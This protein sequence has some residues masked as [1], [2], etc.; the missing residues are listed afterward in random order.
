MSR[1]K[2]RKKPKKGFR[3]KNKNTNPKKEDSNKKNHGCVIFLL[4]IFLPILFGLIG[5]NGYEEAFVFCF[6]SM[7][8]IPVYLMMLASGVGGSAGGGSGS[9]GDGG[10]DGGGGCGGCGGCGGGCGG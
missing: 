9:G 3:I 6:L 8:I 10:G 7:G 5:A 4:G 1:K 2:N